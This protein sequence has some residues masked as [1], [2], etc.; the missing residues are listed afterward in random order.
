MVDIPN[1]VSYNDYV[2][3]YNIKENDNMSKVSVFS[4]VFY[5]SSDLT[6]AV[7]KRLVD[8]DNLTDD[9]VVDSVDNFRDIV[10]HGC[11]SGC[12]S[13]FIYTRDNLDFLRENLSDVFDLLTDVKYNY[14]KLDD[15]YDANQ[16]CWFVVEW[17]LSDF[18]C[19]YDDTLDWD[20]TENEE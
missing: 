6:R 1:L 20:E 4:E 18:I 5:N 3:Q 16:M 13:A 2:I 17:C 19:A 15:V 8:V 9:T 7:V 14:H 11:E 12:A 10:Q